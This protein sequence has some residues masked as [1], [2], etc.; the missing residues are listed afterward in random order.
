MNMNGTW[1]ALLLGL[2]V[3]AV[4]GW[5]VLAGSETVE[6]EVLDLEKG[7][8]EAIV[9]ADAK[10]VERVWGDD[11]IYTGVRGEIKT[12]PDILAQLKQGS[13]KFEVMKFEDIRVKQYGDTAVVTGRATTK[14]RSKEGE[15]SGQFRYTRVYVKRDGAWQLVCFQGTSIADK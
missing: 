15:I 12:K 2:A 5:P 6:R 4:W 8:S 3:V 9:K 1:S 11:F 13:L 7:I 14:G 10:F